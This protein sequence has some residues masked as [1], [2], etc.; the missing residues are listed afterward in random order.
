MRAGGGV[1]TFAEVEEETRGAVETLEELAA[2]DGFDVGDAR[3]RVREQVFARLFDVADDAAVIPANARVRTERDALRG[4]R[5]GDQ[6]FA[7]HVADERGHD[8]GAR[9]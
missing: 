3:E 7:F 1:G 4:R 6:G 8:V 5:A 9:A 2:V